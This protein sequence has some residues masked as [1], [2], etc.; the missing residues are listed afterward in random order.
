MNID[1]TSLEPG[2]TTQINESLKR[3]SNKWGVRVEKSLKRLTRVK[4]KNVVQKRSATI[5]TT[6]IRIEQQILKRKN[7]TPL[8]GFDDDDTKRQKASH[9]SSNQKGKSK[10]QLNS[11]KNEQKDI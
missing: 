6:S 11:G 9:I 5:P 2:S 3:N 8:D 1:E 4:K 10:S 7:Y